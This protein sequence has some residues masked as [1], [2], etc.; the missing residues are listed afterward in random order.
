MGALIIFKL[1]GIPI[2]ATY[3]PISA[4][5]FPF[6]ASQAGIAYQSNPSGI[7]CATYKAAKLKYRRKVFSDKEGSGLD[8]ILSDFT[9]SIFSI[10]YILGKFKETHLIN[11]KEFVP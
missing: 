6:I 4:G 2:T 8:F 7:P 11:I 9:K 1:H 5:L 3:D 10:N